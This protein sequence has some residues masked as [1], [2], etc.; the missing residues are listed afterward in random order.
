MI[1]SP[2][3]LGLPG[4]PFGV[5]FNGVQFMGTAKNF[6]NSGQPQNVLTTFHL[7]HLT[8]FLLIVLQL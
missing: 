4:G 1:I 7:S 2:E 6:S 5:L 8:I 3:D